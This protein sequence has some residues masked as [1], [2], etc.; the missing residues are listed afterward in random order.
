MVLRGTIEWTATTGA[1]GGVS[2]FH[3][4]N[5]TN[6]DLFRNWLVEFANTWGPLASDQWSATVQGEILTLDTATG[7]MTD[8]DSGSSTQVVGAVVGEAVA[9]STCALLRYQTAAI[10]NG[11][12]VRG[13]TYVPGLPAAELVDGQWAPTFVAD[14]EGLAANFGTQTGAV[15][16]ARPVYD[17]SASPPVLVRPGTEHA[18]GGTNAWPQCAVLRHRRQA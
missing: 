5:G 8:V 7:Q 14:L 2:V 15:V 6:R 10:V 9:D 4:S 17:R 16:Y 12:R 3:A 13:R 11:H 18:I 1:R